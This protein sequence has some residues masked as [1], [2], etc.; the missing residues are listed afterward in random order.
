MYYGVDISYAQGN[1]APR[2]EDF[3]IINA[4]RANVTNNGSPVT[5]SYYHTQVINCRNANKQAGHYFFNGNLDAITCANY[6]VNNLYDFRGGDVLVLDVEAEPG[7]GTVAW[8]PAKVLAFAQRVYKLT[9]VKIGVYLNRSLMDGADWSAV[10]NFGC[11]LWIAYYQQTPP[12]I[13]HWSTWTMWQWTSA[14]GLDKNQSKLLPSQIRTSVT[15]GGAVTIDT[16]T[17]KDM[18]LIRIFADHGFTAADQKGPVYGS[19]ATIDPMYGWRQTSTGLGA[20]GPLDSVTAIANA[21]GFTVTEVHVNHD[22]WEMAKAFVLPQPDINVTNNNPAPDT[23]AL[24]D[25]LKTMIPHEFTLTGKA[26]A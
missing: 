7:T 25:G 4:S 23:Q 20:R 8:T 22:G 19:T 15:G 11:W 6:F 24:L 17:E 5:G 26:T 2:T 1:Y 9:N 3:I 12:P 10:V 18:Q 16:E 13:S 14:G 21:L